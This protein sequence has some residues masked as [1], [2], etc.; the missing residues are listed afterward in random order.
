MLTLHIADYVKLEKQN[1]YQSHEQMLE[2][3]ILL[4]RNLVKIDDD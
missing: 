4:I 1:R 2:F 3:S